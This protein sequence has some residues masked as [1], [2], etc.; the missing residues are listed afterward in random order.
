MLNKRTAEK[1][2]RNY[3][4]ACEKQ[5]IRFKKVILFGSVVS[6]NVHEYS[7]IDIAV[8]S[9]Q[10]T[11]NPVKDWHLL[12]PVNIQYSVIEPHLFDSKYFE[13]GDPFINEIKK[14]GIEIQLK[15]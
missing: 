14:T 6:G 11:G 7:D 5:N 2:V 12:A 8:V 10:F 9:D 13:K 15:R 4:S 1:I 3:I